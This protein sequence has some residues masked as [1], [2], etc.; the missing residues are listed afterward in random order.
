M[1]T[2]NKDIISYD[3]INPS[4]I[5]LNDDGQSMTIICT[6][7]KSTKEYQKL[8]LL[9]NSMNMP[10]QPNKPLIDYKTLGRIEYLTEIKKVLDL[11]NEIDTDFKIYADL[12]EEEKLEIE[13]KIIEE[14]PN[15]DK[16]SN[17]FKK[18]FD[19]RR[20]VEKIYKKLIDVV[21]SYVFTG[22]NFVKMILILYR[23]SANIPVIMMGETGYGK[24][25]LIRIISELKMNEIK[26]FMQVLMM[27]IFSN[28]WWK[29]SL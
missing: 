28:L 8:Y 9:Y 6:M 19:E 10:G 18:L 7:D 2:D 4:L 15:L 1:L 21:G 26:I 16:K 14:N 23:I 22:D 27:M 3:K 25:S 24:T 11:K 29:I 5:F 12:K 17:D 13:N 20:P